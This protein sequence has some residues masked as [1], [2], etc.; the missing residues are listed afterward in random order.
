MA[1]IF[2]ISMIL[3]LAAVCLLVL[4]SADATEY[5]AP[6]QVPK[7]FNSPEEVQ[8]YLGKLHNYYVM[9]GRPRFG[10]RANF[11]GML[12]RAEDIQRQDDLLNEIQAKITD[13]YD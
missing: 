6:P 2:R 12:N 3:S 9:V 13:M 11:D 4:S 1:N 7:K 8:Q 10:K 5:P